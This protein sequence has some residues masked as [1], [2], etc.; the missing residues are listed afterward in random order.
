M[1][2]IAWDWGSVM[3]SKTFFGLG[4][5]SDQVNLCDFK[6]DV[7][8]AWSI[9]NIKVYFGPVIVSVDIPMS[10]KRIVRDDSS[11]NTKRIL[12]RAFG[13]TNG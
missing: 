11:R 8:Y 13:Y 6:D 4:F 3:F 9:R 12:D 10:R 2:R 1:K 5:G 7:E